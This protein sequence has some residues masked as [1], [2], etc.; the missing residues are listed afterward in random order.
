[1]SPLIKKIKPENWSKELK[2]LAEQ[3][4]ALAASLENAKQ[5]IDQPLGYGDVMMYKPQL[6]LNMQKSMRVMITKTLTRKYKESIAT[7]ISIF[8]VC[9]Y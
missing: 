9:K 4:P 2:E 6:Y 8:N 7:A 1:M 3:H 5:N